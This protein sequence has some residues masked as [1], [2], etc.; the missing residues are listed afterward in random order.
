MKK[1]IAFILFLLMLFTPLIA[2]YNEAGDPATPTDLEPVI[3]D[4]VIKSSNMPQ[5]SIVAFNNAAINGHIRGS[6]YVGGTLRG[7]Q[8]IDDGSINGVAASDSYVYNN[9]SSVTFKGRTSEQGAESYR[10]LSATSGSSTALYWKNFIKNLPNNEI[11][12]YLE[13]NESGVVDIYPYD[14][15]ANIQF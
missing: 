1:L 6:I 15:Q 9:E 10:Y 4:Y 5:Y 3:Y 7:S 2:A 8:F 11:Y 14:Y 13:P 12:I